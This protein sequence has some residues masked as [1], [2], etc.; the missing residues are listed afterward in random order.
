M[1]RSKPISSAACTSPRGSA[2]RSDFVPRTIA[3]ALSFFFP[4]TAPQPFL[5]A[6]WP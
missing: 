1:R 2:A 4:I 3:T 5:E 6:T